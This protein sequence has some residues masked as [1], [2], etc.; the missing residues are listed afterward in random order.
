[1]DKAKLLARLMATFLDELDEQVQTINDELLA[2]EKN[3]DND[4]QSERP[5]KLFRCA[6]SLKG[7]SRAVDLPGIERV[8]HLMEDV[9]SGF[10]DQKLQPTHEVC[11]TLFE[12]ADVIG[13][14]GQLL[15]GKQPI[16]N[17]ALAA[18]L[19]KLEQVARG[20]EKNSETPST[21]TL[22]QNQPPA[23]KAKSVDSLPSADDR[24]QKQPTVPSAVDS[25]QATAAP[26]APKSS[27][28]QPSASAESTSVVTSARPLPSTIRVAEQKLQSLLAG[29]GELLVARQR[30]ESRPTEIESLLEMVAKWRREWHSVSGTLR[31]LV[32]QDGK[33]SLVRR[34]TML[35]DRVSF[36]IEQTGE[37]LSHL[38][39]EL[40]RFSRSLITDSRQLRHASEGLQEDVLRVRMIPFAEACGGLERAVH[41]VCH[42][43]NKEVSLVIEGGD[44]EV[45]RAVLEELRNPLLHLVRNAIDH[46]IE[47]TEERRKLGKPVPATLKVS[48]AVHGAEV[49]IV[50]S[51]DG[52]GLNLDRIRKRVL[53]QNIPEPADDRELARCIFLPGFST[54]E[55]VTDVSGRGVGMDVVRNRIESL[56]GRISIGTEPGLGTRFTLS[57]PLT[58]TMVSALFV[59]CGSQ[60]FALPTSTVTKLVRF[61]TS[62]LKKQSGQFV[63]PLGEA[64]V[65]VVTLSD[66]LEVTSTNEVR[67]RQTAVLATVGARR[68]LFVVD[69]VIVEQEAVVK[70]LG[71]RIHSVPHVSGAITLPSGEFALLLN[72]AM[73]IESAERNESK[74]LNPTFNRIPSES[75]SSELQVVAQRILVVDDSMTT[76][77]LLKSILETAGY[78][79]S[80]ASDGQD[81]WEQ[82][83]IDEVDLVVSDVD[84]PRMT[85]FELTERIRSSSSRGQLPIILVTSRDSEDDKLR[86]VEVGADAY[87]VKSAFDQT[88]ILATIEQFL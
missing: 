50:V 41:D 75:E 60:S 23:T 62:A 51:D 80:S 58:L 65:R 32:D 64:P 42:S 81:A 49:D 66:L 20:G 78:D 15:R 36:T 39:E 22:S 53:E 2:L 29:T 31:Q 40:Q 69:E 27:E 30:I 47:S 35:K 84:M 59:R 87:L 74:T 6:H 82:L 73:L 83:Q 1:M 56:R 26:A 19:P 52:R 76:R 7:A 79:V 44:I 13:S 33:D 24:S 55:T 10:R 70:T 38:E 11:A 71:V 34:S 86:G 5:A 16:D 45:D 18:L 4:P 25:A 68:M 3:A 17:A 57:V 54:A 85:G 77:T 37:R 67:D 21:P 88:N 14:S 43:T 9:F 48:A 63:L 12:A 46:G 28:D 61:E 72:T 8:C